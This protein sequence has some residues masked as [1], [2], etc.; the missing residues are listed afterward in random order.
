MDY[1][2]GPKP[3]AENHPERVAH[4][5]KQLQVYAYLIE[6]RY[7]KKVSRMHLYYTNCQN[8]DPL[9]TFDWTQD[10]IDATVSEISET[11]SNI[12]N[13]FFEGSVTNSYAC[14]FCDMRYVCGKAAI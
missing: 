8:D 7:G 4:Y 6:K 3:D 14:T 10:A 12:E 11:I 9:I 1:K 5:R 2:T 13:K